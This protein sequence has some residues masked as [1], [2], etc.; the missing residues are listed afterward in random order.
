MPDLSG[1]TAPTWDGELSYDFD[2]NCESGYSTS[3]LLNHTPPAATPTKALF[4]VSLYLRMQ[5][6]LTSN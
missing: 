6:Q 3:L 1:E 5:M 2:F 4:K